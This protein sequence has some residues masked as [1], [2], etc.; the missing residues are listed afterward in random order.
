MV[1]TLL[2]K[3]LG[4]DKTFN[5][6]VKAKQGWLLSDWSETLHVTTSTPPV[7]KRG[8]NGGKQMDHFPH[9][10]LKE[11]RRKGWDGYL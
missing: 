8:D 5:F 4:K 11:Y 3:G 2:V 6:I 7:V 9:A 1:N 10:D